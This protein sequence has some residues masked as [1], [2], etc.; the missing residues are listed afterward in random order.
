MQR[1]ELRCIYEGEF[2][3]ASVNDNIIKPRFGLAGR[4]YAF[5]ERVNDC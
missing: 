5:M 3:H 2:S 4:R 1:T